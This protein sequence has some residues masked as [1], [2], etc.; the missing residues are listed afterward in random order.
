[1]NLKFLPKPEA[2]KLCDL[3]VD[4]IQIHFFSL[5]SPPKHLNPGSQLNLLENHTGTLLWVT[6]HFI[7]SFIVLLNKY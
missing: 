6:S 7:F 1:M 3:L 5:L 2:N 4:T